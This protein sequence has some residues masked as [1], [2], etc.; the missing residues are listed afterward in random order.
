M[1]VIST[2]IPVWNRAHQVGQAIDSALQQELPGADWSHE[3]IVSDDGSTDDL[4]GALAR[5][6]SRIVCLKLQR[7]QGAATA[8]NTAI[9]AARGDFIAFLDSDDCWLP[10]KLR[11]QIGFMQS[12]GYEAS[13]TAFVLVRHN[14]SEVVSPRYETG[15]LDLSDLAC[16]CFVS[17]GSTLVCDRALFKNIGF[18]DTSLLRLEDWEWL[19]RLTV[20][21]QLGFLAEPF[22]RIEASGHAKAERVLAALEKIEAQQSAKLSGPVLRRFKSA[23]ALER[24]AAYYREGRWAAAAFS[25]TK[26]LLRSP[27]NHPAMMAVLHNRYG[28]P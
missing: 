22:A 21:I 3:I 17:P 16:G 11:S 15:A 28:W 18:L 6:G 14:R 25:L 19:L 9:N 2:I 27:L 24:A 7:N 13:C 20:K 23:V 10:G 8:R 12:G 1:P 4:A 5:Y 26:S